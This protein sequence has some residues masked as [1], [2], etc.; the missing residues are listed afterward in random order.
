MA[1]T[2]GWVERSE[3]HRGQSCAEEPVTDFAARNPSRALM[4]REHYGRR[5]HHA[6]D[7]HVRPAPAS[8]RDHAHFM[9]L[10]ATF[11]PAD[12]KGEM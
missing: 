6:R 3:T 1:Q 9:P 10:A 2:V 7:H 12:S 4:A 5:R 8:R 11:L